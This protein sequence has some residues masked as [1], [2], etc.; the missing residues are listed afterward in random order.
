MREYK[1]AYGRKVDLDDPKTY[2]YL[3]DTEKELDTLMFREIGYAICYMDY[4]PSRKGLFPKRK[5]KVKMVEF[6]NGKEVDVN[7]ASYGQRK[8]V[9]VLIQNFANER[10]NN[11]G[12]LM[13]YKEQIFL[14]QDETE[15]MY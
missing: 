11:Y 8:R 15:N 3:P 14:F 9:E 4:F 7:N 5:R 2:E 1:P 6:P 12:N 13:W 10:R